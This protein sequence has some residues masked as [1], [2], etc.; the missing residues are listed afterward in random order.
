MKKERNILK[1][2]DLYFQ[3]NHTNF[4]KREYSLSLKGNPFPDFPAIHFDVKRADD[5]IE[6]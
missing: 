6:N 3:K 2:N 5:S 4:Q 1:Q